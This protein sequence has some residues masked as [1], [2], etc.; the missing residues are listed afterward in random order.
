[1]ASLLLPNFTTYGSPGD[2]LQ[3]DFVLAEEHFV[4]AAGGIGSGKSIG[5]AQR[6]ILAACGRLGA[7]SI[8]TP[9]LGVVTAPTYTML[10][11]ASLRTFLDFA[12]GLVTDFNKNDM[13]ATLAN[14]SEIL[15]RSAD[16]PDRLRGPTIAW[17]WGDEAAYSSDALY[18][19]MVGRLRQYGQLGHL[20]L[21]TTPKGRNWIWQR[22]KQKPQPSTK[23]FQLPTWAN[24]FLDEAI[25]RAWLDSYA[26]D[27]A[28]QELEGE[29]IAYDGLIYA[30]FD[31]DLHVR[32]K[33]ADKF[34][35]TLAGVDWGFNHPGVML[36]F[37]LDYDGRLW[38]IHEEYKRQ[39]NIEDW[40][41]IAKQL[42]A[43]YRP[44]TWYCDPSE[45]SYIAKLKAVG[46]KA[47]EANNEVRPGIQRVANRLVRRADGLPKLLVASYAANTI[48]EFEQYKWAEVRGELREEPMK[49][50]DHTMDALRYVV[51]ALDGA[52]DNPRMVAKAEAY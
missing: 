27:F 28:L 23:L 44:S 22:F 38:L 48:T 18:K 51:N 41:E 19:I 34:V 15:F 10:K 35:H 11:D 29:F 39:T 2:G 45:P 37:G 6:A 4:C 43:T 3:T 40:A 47:V 36:I 42:N 12:G 9:N 26:G 25:Y 17:W 24:P 5:G 30:G 14:G 32:T 46:C 21:T 50:N 16:N 20:W 8:R 7:K 31:R 49:A 1:M 52:D 13:K 33:L